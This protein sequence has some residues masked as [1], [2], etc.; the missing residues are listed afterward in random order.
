MFVFQKI[1]KLCEKS[2]WILLERGIRGFVRKSIWYVT[3]RKLHDQ[4]AQLKKVFADVLFINGCTLPHPSRYRVTH[5]AEQL[6]ANAVISRVVFYDD[7][8][9]DLVKHYRLFIF[10]RCPWTEK[11]EQFIRLAKENN[12]T[13]LFD[14]D[15]LVIDDKYTRQIKYVQAMSPQDKALYDDGVARMQRVLRMCDAAITTT[16]R[17]GKELRHY[18]PEVFVNRNTASERMVDLSMRAINRKKERQVN[19]PL[20]IGYFSGSITHN[21]D[22]QMI[23]PVLVRV[24]R[25]NPNV[26]LVFA[27]EI[28]IPPAL[29]S[30][31]KRIIFQSFTDWE[32]L[33]QRI[34]AVDINIAPLEATIFNEA[35]SE[36][37]WVE[38]A[39][40]NVPT[41]AS[42]VGAMR[43]MIQN[44]ETGILCSTNAEWYEALDKLISNAAERK[45][46]AENAFQFVMDHCTTIS[47]GFSLAEYVKKKMIPNVAFILPSLQVSGGVMVALKHA[48]LLKKAGYD[49]LILNDDVDSED[50]IH[51]GTALFV[52]SRKQIDIYGSFNKAVA[53]LW[54]TVEF[55]NSYPN[56]DECFYL[57]Q[58]Y[59][60]GFY[61]PGKSAR[62]QANQTY[63]NYLPLKYITI[64]RWCQRWLKNDFEKDACYAPNGLDI[65]L[66]SPNPRKI[67]GKIRILIEGNSDSDYKNVDESF[68]IVD[69]LDAN[70]FEIWYLSCEGQPKE[71]YRIDRF[72]HNIPH[73]KVPEI[74]KQC[75]I[76]LKTSAL[77][78]FSYPPLEMM[79]T[80]GYVV[81]VTNNGNSEYLI[82][83]DNCLLYQ[84]GDLE[85]AI[86][87]IERI[88]RDRD[89][90]E[91]L[92]KG[93][94]RTAESRSWDRVEKEILNLY[95]T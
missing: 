70:Q 72:F 54:S 64:S 73:E 27:G 85:K 22:I 39:L 26:Q 55:L 58:C 90:R 87:A 56:I 1:V 16:E 23:L 75:H 33:P 91:R 43:K 38:A 67:E 6:L 48:Q 57:V 89:L 40:V 50:V 18:V 53:T 68:K 92:Y 30:F 4:N 28:D 84:K 83:E 93:G 19:D 82:D 12:K 46:L 94:I 95:E 44:D 49:V 10:F 31:E 66:F 74:Y 14:I 25:E 15:D 88:C 71:W 11:I 63:N 2:I 81:A 65:N 35:K 3:E 61:E 59:E 24:M 86:N 62:L 9:L 5:Q 45:R 20:K 32:K 79:A 37:K 80:G 34:A 36:N 8:T 78:G 42:R 60:T 77:E 51:D 52:L 76:L 69:Q 17:L 29:Q 7:L 13:V 21:D 41:V 47:T